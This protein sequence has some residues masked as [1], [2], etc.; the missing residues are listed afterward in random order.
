[1]RKLANILTYWPFALVGFLVLMAIIGPM[2]SPFDPYHVDLTQRLLAP[3]GPYLLGTDELGRDLLTRLLYGARIS[4]LAAFCIVA[5]GAGAGTIIGAF[6]GLLGSWVDTVIM[7]LTEVA[8]ALPALVIALALTAALGPSLVNLVIALGI[9]SIPGY[10]RLSRGQALSLR[11]REYVIAADVMGGGRLHQLSEH[12]LPNL[13]PTIVIFASSHLGGALLAASALSF[14]GLGAQPPMPEW[15]AIVSAGRTSFLD[16]WW[17][18]VFPGCF[19]IVTALAFN[20]S[21]D[22]LRDMFD[23]NTGGRE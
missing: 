11:E 2:L 21:G 17:Y 6:A 3:G 7:R 20:L 1:M 12:V 16:A 14:I 4:M 8:M 5:I 18:A 23:P 22:L 9:L 10:I 13:L 19:I 15:G